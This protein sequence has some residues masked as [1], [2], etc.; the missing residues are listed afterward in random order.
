[1][2]PWTHLFQLLDDARVTRPSTPGCFSVR[3][4]PHSATGWI[5]C[6][7]AV[8]AAFL[9][10]VSSNARR[11]ASVMLPA[12]RARHGLQ[13]VVDDGVQQQTTEVSLVECLSTEPAVTSLFVRALAG[14]CLAPR[15]TPLAA[16]D[17]ATSVDSLLELFRDFAYASDAEILGLWAELF[18]LVSAPNPAQMARYWRLSGSSRYDFGS[19]TERVDVKATTSG[20]RHHEVSFDQVH[21][22]GGVSAAVVSILTERVADGTSVRELWDAALHSAPDSQHRIDRNCIRTLG[23]D[24]QIAQEQAFDLHRAKQ[25]LQVYS[26]VDVPRFMR[27]PAGVSRVRFVSDFSQ[28]SPWTGPTPSASGPIALAI[29]CRIT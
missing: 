6:S 4:L 5:G 22:P 16:E 27:M 11:P 29:G 17:V 2:N 19:E 18:V 3:A 12:I 28:G 10:R 13:V 9:F 8:G 23:R 26:V 1:V 25:S 7:E 24:W 21:P 20:L 14:I 15:T